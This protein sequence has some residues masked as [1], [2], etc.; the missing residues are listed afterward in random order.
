MYHAQTD[1]SSVMF[2]TAEIYNFII[3]PHMHS[4]KTFSNKKNIIYIRSFHLVQCYEEQL[5]IS[6]TFKCN[7]KIKLTNMCSYIRLH[8]HCPLCTLCHQKYGTG[9]HTFILFSYLKS[10][11]S[12]F[13]NHVNKLGYP[14]L[15]S[16]IVQNFFVLVYF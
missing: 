7:D 2:K 13:W 10:A 4:Y 11:S 16:R 9:S 14:H 6:V 8:P 5:C 1:N 15:S 12:S 3:T